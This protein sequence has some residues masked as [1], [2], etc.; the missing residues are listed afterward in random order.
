MNYFKFFVAL[1]VLIGLLSCSKIS[2]KVTER[3]NKKIDETIDKNLQ[4]MD[5]SLKRTNIDSLKKSMKQ[6]D[7]ISK[8]MDKKFNTKDED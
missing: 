7:S 6:L 1:I 4:Q 8:E 3:V 2:E 5:S